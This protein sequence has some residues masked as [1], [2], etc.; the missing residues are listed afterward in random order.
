[1]LLIG[2]PGRDEESRSL[3]RGR[4]MV[5]VER[6]LRVD[7]EHVDLGYRG[8]MSRPESLDMALQVTSAEW[9]AR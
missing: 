1:M 8:G 9:A 3:A 6:D 5:V 7:V 4:R 2:C